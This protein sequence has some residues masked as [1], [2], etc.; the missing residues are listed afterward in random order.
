MSYLYE[1]F[2]KLGI[3]VINPP[4]AVANT[5][6]KWITYE[7]LASAGLPQPLSV[8]VSS[9]DISKKDD[10]E[11]VKKLRSLYK[12]EDDSNKYVCKLL[13]G[14][15]G[16]GVF[17]CREKNILSILQAIFAVKDDTLVMI[18]KAVDIKDGD[19]RANI[20]TINGK[21]EIINAVRRTKGKDSDFRTNLSLGGH[22]EEIELNGEQKKL[23]LSAAKASGLI[24]AGVD[25]IEDEK[26]NLYI[27]EVNGAPGTPYDVEDQED[28]LEKNTKFY[29]SLL[30]KINGLK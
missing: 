13:N 2:T 5:S 20:L 17:C 25:M 4:S 15:G 21:Q 12:K 29:A 9:N 3:L 10:T 14:H 7:F 28:L 26:G 8:L 19:I 11:L 1:E 18:Q 16:H 27:I 23:A 6:N 24:W 30:S 22:A